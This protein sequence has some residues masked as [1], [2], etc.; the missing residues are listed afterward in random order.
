MFTP[1]LVLAFNI[2]HGCT[3]YVLRR[4]FD[5]ILSHNLA[6]AKPGALNPN[7]ISRQHD[8]GSAS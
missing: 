8:V 6:E 4:S 2:F 3:V 7:H 5:N 1:H